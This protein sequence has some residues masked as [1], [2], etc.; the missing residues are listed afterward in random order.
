MQQYRKLK[1]S[2][3][4]MQ[5]G[6]HQLVIEDAHQQQNGSDLMT[7]FNL[8]DSSDFRVDLFTK[9]RLVYYIFIIK[10]KSSYPEARD[11]LGRILLISF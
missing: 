6:V 5:I 8:S 9:G 11:V 2:F 7:G 3:H 10:L 4:D 1:R